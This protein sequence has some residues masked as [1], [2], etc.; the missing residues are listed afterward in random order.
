MNKGNIIER[1]G[2]LIKEETLNCIS[3]DKLAPNT[4]IL[5][6]SAPFDGYYSCEPQAHKPQYLY[7]ALNGYFSFETISRATQ[8]VHKALKRPID[9]VTG[10]ITLFGVT[11][12]V[13][14]L[15]NLEH[16][17]DV[18]IIQ[19][20]Y[21][22]E[23]ITF[24]KRLWKISNGKTMIKLRKFFYLEPYDVNMFMDRAEPH[25]AYFLIPEQM[26]YERFKQLTKE[27]KYDPNYFYFDGA[28]AFFYENGEINDMIRIYRENFTIDE[29]KE[30]RDKYFNLM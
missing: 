10:N 18:R 21:L 28:I 17:D 7:L 14:R 16:Y 2:G 9:A 8:N 30:I 25:H 1:F 13:I 5:E 29:I 15:R 20:L 19:S 6:S 3:D 22:D 23:G 11:T 4:C 12:Q 27:V 26:D 24:R